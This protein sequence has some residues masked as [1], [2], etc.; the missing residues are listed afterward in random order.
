MLIGVCS[1]IH[2]NIPNLNKMTSILKSYNVKTLIFCG[3]FCS[4]IPISVLGNYDG[5]VHCVFGDNDGDR[6][7]MLNIVNSVSK[8]V[9]L[10]GEYAELEFDKIKI[11]ATH[12]PFYA[13]ALSKTGDFKAVFCGH[14]HEYYKE[15]I[16]DCLLLN[17][18]EVMGYFGGATCAIYDTDTHDAERINL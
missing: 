10:Y 7:S 15:L 3:D 12:Y 11:T 18:G 5:S 6:F 17:P 1:D 14:R 13:E 9:T 8:N 4:P 16:G 2:D